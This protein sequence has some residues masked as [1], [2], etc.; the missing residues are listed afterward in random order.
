MTSSEMITQLWKC[1]GCAA[2]RIWGLNTP[3]D[4][5]AQARL[6]CAGCG[7]TCT[8]DFDGFGNGTWT[9][10]RQGEVA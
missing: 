4:T 9:E 10:Y 6:H 7:K 2:I 8:H 1:L 3:A 5:K